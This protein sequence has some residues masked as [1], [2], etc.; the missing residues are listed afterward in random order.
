MSPWNMKNT[1][2]K[3]EPGGNTQVMFTERGTFFGYNMLVNDFRSLKI[4][5]DSGYP[6][7]YDATHSVQLPTGLGTISGGQREFIPSLIRGAVACGI[8][9]LFMEVHDEPDNAL[10][11]PATQLPLNLL[12]KILGQAAAVHTC[13][14]EL[15]ER[16][17]EDDV[18]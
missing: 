17:G 5:R 11:D 4:M 16:W 1:A 8:H 3:I 15:V 7:C 14:R 10:S 18:E 9:A 12:D 6:V 13:Q 2:R